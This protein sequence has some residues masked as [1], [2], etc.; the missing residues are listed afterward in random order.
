MSK[1]D[2][3]VVFDVIGFGNKGCVSA[4]GIGTVTLT[5]GSGVDSGG[6]NSKGFVSDDFIIRWIPPSVPFGTG[7][8]L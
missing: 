5:T 4:T 1:G 2:L 7:I 8:I 6:F 3:C